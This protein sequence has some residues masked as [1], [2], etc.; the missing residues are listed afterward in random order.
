VVD[1]LYCEWLTGLWNYQGTILQK[2]RQLPQ[3]RSV[4][5][6]YCAEPNHLS[7]SEEYS[8]FRF[9]LPRVIRLAVFST[10]MFLVP[11]AEAQTVTTLVPGPGP[12]DDALSLD[13]DGNLFAS[14]YYGG[15]ITRIAPDG[16]MS[17]FAGGLLNPNGTTFDA[18]GNLYVAE[19]GGNRVWK[20]PPD[21]APEVLVSGITNPTGVVF[22][23][24]G[25]LLIAQ[26]S[27]SRI[28]QRAPDGT[29]STFMSGGNLNGPVGL[30]MDSE[31]NLYIGNF[32]D[33]KILKRTPAGAISI[34]GDVPG[35]LGFIALAGDAIY[36]TGFQAHRIYRAPVD[37]SGMT[38][39]AGTGIPGQQ[40]GDVDT[41]RFNGPNGIVASP[42]GSTLYVCDY[43]TR[44]IRVITGLSAA[45]A[46]DEMPENPLDRLSA[47][48]NPF[49]PRVTLRFDLATDGPTQ[50]EIFDARGRR[51]GQIQEGF[52]T[53]GS[54]EL[55][56]DGSRLASG[57]YFARLIT[58][59][60]NTTRKLILAK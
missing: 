38:I 30:Q 34:I 55:V 1:I 20:L 7:H 16:T 2:E 56:F 59:A 6:Y 35:W 3:K 39:F 9:S 48:P 42:D 26:Y 41:A 53:A 33:G 36:A 47:F 52:R 31:G 11:L 5:V 43:N 17:N 13:A 29:L 45:S 57:V 28:T 19:A 40:D 37:G 24:A 50:L 10:A 60:G 51:V 49:N 54:H 22:D 32:T 4:L 44:S 8:M 18:E 14:Q 23:G 12:F 58:A 25:N 46:V 15:D 21:S 27:L